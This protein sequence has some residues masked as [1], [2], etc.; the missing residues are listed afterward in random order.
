VPELQSL[1]LDWRLGLVVTAVAVAGFLRGFVGFG[2]ALITVPVLSLVFGPTLAVAIS[3]IMGLPA[4]FQLVPEAIR[5]AERPFVIPIGL[6][7]FAAT[8]IG[9][10]VL[11]VADPAVMK[12]AI[13]V[14]VLAMV[15]VLA[16]GWRLQG[17]VGPGKLIAA[18]VTGGLVQGVAGIGGPPVVA[19]ALSRP[20]DPTQQRGN[21][22]GLMTAVALSSVPALLLYGLVT[23]Q[24][25]IYGV[26][27]FP[28]Y[29]LATA[30]GARYFATGGQAH[31]RRAAMAVLV[32]VALAT[33]VLAVRSYLQG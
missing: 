30:L 15:A 21:V 31:Y 1:T 29:S 32:G 19:M 12:I 14:L 20:G 28:V 17:H 13:S 11:V 33:L 26:L 10:W 22:L 27:L 3:T 9:T 23:R 25:L 2:A 5:R 8:P 18:G 16:S 7:A 6:A 4:I 24:A